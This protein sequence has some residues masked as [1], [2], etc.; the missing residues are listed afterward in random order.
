MPLFLL[1]VSHLGV[2]LLVIC[3]QLL[4]L[5]L[6]LAELGRSDTSL[7]GL[8]LQFLLPVLE[9][10]TPLLVGLDL[11]LVVVDLLLQRL[12]LLLHRAKSLS[13]FDDLVFQLVRDVL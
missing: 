11:A 3:L 8:D 5:V 9:R 1:Q 7:V 4:E 12:V 2:A 6:H 10:T 13:E